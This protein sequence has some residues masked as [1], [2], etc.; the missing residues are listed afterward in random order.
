MNPSITTEVATLDID[1]LCTFIERDEPYEMQKYWRQVMDGAGY[2]K[3]PRR[4]LDLTGYYRLMAVLM[5]ALD[6]D[7]APPSVE[8][9]YTS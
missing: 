4:D 8:V 1:K 6:P 9:V 7:A 3:N 5:T 2:A